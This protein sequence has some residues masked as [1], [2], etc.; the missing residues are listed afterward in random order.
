MLNLGNQRYDLGQLYL[1]QLQKEPEGVANFQAAVTAYQKYLT[2]DP[3]NMNVLVDMATSAFYSNQ[4]DL[5]EKT[6]KDALA[7]DP[8]HVQAN[9]N[10]GVFL[11]HLRQDY[12]AALQ[13]FEQVL[14]LKPDAETTQKANQLITSIKEIQKKPDSSGNQQSGT[15]GTGQTPNEQSGGTTSE[16]APEDQP[17]Q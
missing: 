3:K 6:Y 2:T 14:A 15:P 1:F 17:K 4:A 10:Y 7:I 16:P 8:K 11:M 12:Q 13:Q 9:L 5:A